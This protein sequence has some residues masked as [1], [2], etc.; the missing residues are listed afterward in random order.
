[1][2]KVLVIEDNDGVRSLICR[3][4]QR[5]GHICVEAKDGREGFDLVVRHKLDL[6]ITDLLMPKQEGIETIEQIKELEPD[7]P[8]IAISGVVRDGEFSVL[9]DAMLMGADAALEKPFDATSLVE[10]VERLL[11][12]KAKPAADGSGARQDSA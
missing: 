11:N 9:D 8:I 4:L 3:A 5:V 10:V 7:L 1:M 6:V 2:A 12:K